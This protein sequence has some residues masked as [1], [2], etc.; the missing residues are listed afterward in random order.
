[1][2]N[3]ASATFSGF[4][5]DNLAKARE[6]YVKTLGLKLADEKMG[7]MLSLPGGGKLFI[8]E[9]QIC[10]VVFVFNGTV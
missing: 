8:Y 2:L 10:K 1:M 5:T 9:K 7:L 3:N 6:F 4:S